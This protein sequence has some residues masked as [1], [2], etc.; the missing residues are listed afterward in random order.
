M[1][2]LRRSLRLL[3]CT[4]LGGFA[5][6][7]APPALLIPG[8]PLAGELASGETH[9]YRTELPAGHAWRIAVEQRGID[10]ELA[11]QGPDGRRIAVDGPFDRQGIETLVVEPETAGTFEVSVIAREPAAPAG[12]YEIRL[13]ELPRASDPDRHRLAAELAMSRAGEQI[14]RASCRERV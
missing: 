2:R 8:Q 3:A 14:G 1:S 10:V 5:L 4:L 6:A 9:A 13:D 11:I 7:A 12:R